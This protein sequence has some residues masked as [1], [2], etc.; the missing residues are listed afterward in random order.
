[1]DRVTKFAKANVKNKKDFGEDARLAFKRHIDDLARSEKND[2]TFPYRFD[3]AKAEDIIELANKLTIAE[4]EGDEQFTCAG[5]QEFILGSL[6]G[7]VHK[8]TGK[9]RFTDSYV[10]VARQQGKS[11]L[12][13]ILGIKCCNF[14]NYNYGQIYCTATKA[15]Q[16]RIV[17]KEII[18]FINAD[19]DLKELFDIKDYKSEITGKITSTVIRALGRDTH[20]I[21]GFRPYLGIVD[22]Y[23]AHKDNQMYKLLKGGTRKL[24]QSLISVITTAGFN[25]NAPCY[26]LYK[27]CR[28]VLRGI[29]V[30]ERQFIYIA[31]MDEKDDI[32]DPANWIK[33]C[34]LTGK[35]P[36]L[37]AAM[38]EDA[39]KAQSMGG[40]E[41]RD[42]LTKAL[43]IWVTNAETAFLD[44][45]EWEKCGSERDL[46]DF[47]GKQVIVGLD[48]SSGGDLTSYCLEFPYE[49]EETGDRRYF[50]HSQS[51]MPRHRL[52]EHMDLEDNAPYVI[53]QK[54]GLLTVTTAAGG[55]KTDYKAILSSLHDIVD[56]YQLD[57]MAIGYDPHNA[58]AF[59]LDLEDFGCDLIEIKQSARSLNDATVDFQ[60]EVKAHNMEYNKGNVL[61]TRSMNDAIISEPNS[62]G[63]IKIDKMLQKNRIDPCDAAICAHKIA[64]G[65]D[66]ETVDINDAVDAFLGMD[67]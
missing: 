28:R 29:D 52:Q 9:R 24:K 55:I 11:V 16:A 60:L 44:L 33:C 43:N 54:Q 50:L 4:G 27:Y 23:H 62:F 51:F 63:E 26:D 47:I 20:T 66:L 7:W 14:D 64:M 2:P 21:D 17:L 37:V 56:K 40:A 31:Q 25:L 22:E 5:F 13:A 1:M 57:V 39:H 53:W 49:D 34:P 32:W 18:K 58:S 46:R 8:E 10:Q 12:N 45:A 38:Q 30:N 6:F 48:L 61:L 35:D 41:L 36:E 67:E 59:L 15:D 3:E 42:F 65:A 19:N